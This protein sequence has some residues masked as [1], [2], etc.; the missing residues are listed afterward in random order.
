MILDYSTSDYSCK[1]AFEVGGFG[2]VDGMVR[3]VAGAG[4]FA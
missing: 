4:D 2:E 3:G 1:Q